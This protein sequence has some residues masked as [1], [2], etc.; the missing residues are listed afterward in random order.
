MDQ[1]YDVNLY[2]STILLCDVLVIEVLFLCVLLHA[3]E[4]TFVHIIMYAL[5]QAYFG[6]RYPVDG[7]TLAAVGVFSCHVCAG[8]TTVDSSEI[9]RT[10]VEVGSLSHYL[11]GFFYIPGGCLGFLNHQ[12]YIYIPWTVQCRISFIFYVIYVCGVCFFGWIFV[13]DFPELLDLEW[14]IFDSASC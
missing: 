9:R 10:P 2:L 11:Q 7:W 1:L 13:G 6:G 5:L 14:S 8:C 4:V 12:R 3:I